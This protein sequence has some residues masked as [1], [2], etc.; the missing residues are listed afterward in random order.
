ML[1]IRDVL[2]RLVLRPI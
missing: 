2:S 1:W